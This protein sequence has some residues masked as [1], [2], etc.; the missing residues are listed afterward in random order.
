MARL[1]RLVLPDQPLHIMH[2]GNNRQ[3]IFENDEDMARILND[4][5][6]SLGKADCHLHA[7]VIM[8][9]H[10]H[11]LLTPKNK[12]ELSAFMQSMTNRYVRYFNASRKRTGTIWEGRF[13]SCL[14][15]SDSY[16]FRL[17]KYI[18]MNPVKAGVTTEIQEYPWSSYHHNALG[19]VDQLITEHSL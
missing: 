5:A 10:L 16:L 14:I 11:L 3:N 2:R 4:I 12:Q 6:E 15:D 17:Y 7:Y 1:P 18:E 13:K 19:K 8:T 9:N